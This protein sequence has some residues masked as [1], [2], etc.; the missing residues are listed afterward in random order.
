[1]STR[2]VTRMTAAT[3][4]PVFIIK[5]A[6]SKG[7]SS[8][9]TILADIGGT[10]ARLALH[11]AD[12]PQKAEK[13]KCADYPSL[14][15]ALNDYAA[16]HNVNV[17][18]R[19]LVGTAAHPDAQDV[20]RFQNLNDWAIDPRALRDSG[21][22]MPVIVNDFVA[23]ALGAVSSPRENLHAIRGGSMVRATRYVVLGPGTGLGLGYVEKLGGRWHVQETL[24][25]HMLGACVT[26]EQYMI[27]KVVRRLRGGEMMFIHEDVCSGV[28][29]PVLY[30]AVCLYNGQDVA[31]DTPAAIVA[32]R[33]D[34]PCAAQAMRLLHEFWGL[35][36]HNALV[37]GHAFG[38]VYLDGGLTQHLVREKAF[39]A[40]TFI[41]F[42][43]LEPATVVREHI[44]ATP[45]YAIDDPFVALKGLAVM[46]DDHA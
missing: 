43:T 4:S 1:M 10:H 42:M 28:G 16:R 24:G 26:D 36:A 13:L 37:T 25:G 19:V 23:S 41:K 44:D 20:W 2:T 27:A 38:G 32:A 17:G 15:D 21:W 34:D 39:D 8:M 45:V 31:F 46:A 22:A 14:Q 40:D 11:D 29:L 30:H 12:G 18:G 6:I 35:F 33:H 9:T 3:P 7:A 5:T